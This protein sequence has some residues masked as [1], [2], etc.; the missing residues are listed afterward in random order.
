[1]LRSSLPVGRFFQVDVRM[2][3][4]FP[5]LLVLAIVL[6]ILLTGSPSRGIGLWIALCLA[7]FVRE[8]A[9]TIAAAYAGL[10]L[11]TLFLLPVGGVM[12]FASQDGVTLQP[13]APPN[14][15]WITASG[16]IANFA[17]GLLMLGLSYSIDP[18]VSLLQQP[19]IGLDHV[20][21]SFIWMQMILGAV[22]LLPTPT[23]PSR[24]LLRQR[25]GQTTSTRSRMTLPGAAFS[26]TT[27]VALA[28]IVAGFLMPTHYW[29]II[30]GAFLLLGAQLNNVQALAATDADAILVQEVMLTEYT[31]LSSSDTLRHAL[32]STV[33]SLQDVFPVVRGDRLVGSIARQTLADKLLTDGDGYLQGHMV[34][35]MQI[36]APAEKLVDALRRAS[37]LNSTEF[38]PVVED[39]TMI[40]ILTQQSLGRAVQ[41]V[42]ATRPALPQREQPQ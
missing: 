34:R 5:L 28:M 32:A 8:I 33:H 15:R 6:S 1:M 4:S 24:Q 39:D 38:I 26:L 29:L 14:T 13:D 25:P 41:Q 22:S 19:W 21:R 16:P 10:R 31:L 30:A 27:G 35:A 3:L 42:K 7:V 20:L 17:A 40:G 12:A 18:Q 23:M 2:H 37:S 36:A 9:R 11:R